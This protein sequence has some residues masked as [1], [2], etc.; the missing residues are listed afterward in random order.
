MY[1]ILSFKNFLNISSNLLLYTGFGEKLLSLQITQYSSLFN[2][3]LI[4]GQI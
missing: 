4:K 3:A 2:L 1:F